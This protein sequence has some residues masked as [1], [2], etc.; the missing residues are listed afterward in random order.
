MKLK[1]TIM[2]VRSVLI[3]G[4]G[5]A[6]CCA[7][8]AFARRGCKV[9][10]AEKQ[11]QWHFQS[12][13]IF[14]YSNGLESLRELDVLPAIIDA[15]YA[16]TD[17]RNVYLDHEGAP[18]V[19]TVY[20]PGRRGA[21][22]ILG[23]RRAELHRVLASK[24]TQHA[25]DIRLATTVRRLPNSEVSG[26]IAVEFSDGNTAD[27]DLLV[28]A[29][30]IRS[31]LRTAIAGELEPRDSGFGV[32]R[33]VHARPGDLTEKIMMMGIGK[34]L[35]IMPISTDQLYLFGTVREPR[36]ER[37]AT[38]ALPNLMRARFAE[39]GAP[40][41]RFLDELSA[42]SDVLYTRVE[43]VIA[44]LPWHKGRVVMIGDAA[45]A[46]TPFMGQGGAMAIE[47]AV[48]LADMLSQSGTIEAT[49]SGFG[50]RRQ[51][52]CAFVQDRS[53]QVGEAG[54]EEDAQARERRNAH[55]R[56]H[57]QQQVD[58][59]FQQLVTMSETA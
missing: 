4:G 15:G 43:E 47:D 50:R 20:P 10:L 53:R 23:I 49:L 8:I 45:H 34:R 55:M 35:G 48:V 17:G 32:W 7:A 16:I 1:E 58:Q 3:V 59:F 13:G 21:P 14:V 9:V 24:L 31:Q 51:P 19:D 25:V 12:S 26:P 39:F 2:Q 40:A 52:V 41:R 6:G 22:P 18:I 46:S 38:D 27:F 56:S 37:Y 11:A 29:D 36:G 54:A 44:P 57:A 28:A 5:I 42:G 33:S 30:G